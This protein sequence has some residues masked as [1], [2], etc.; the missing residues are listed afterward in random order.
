MEFSKVT[1]LTKLAIVV[2][3]LN[4]HFSTARCIPGTECD[5]ILQR[6]NYFNQLEVSDTLVINNVSL[7]LLAAEG[8]TDRLAQFNNSLVC[9]WTYEADTNTSRLPQTLY[10][11]RCST[12]TWCD[13]KTGHTYECRP[14]DEYRVPVAISRECDIF[15]Q[16]EWTLSFERVA[17]ACYPSHI[18]RQTA[19]ICQTLGDSS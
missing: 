9:P 8:S 15:G 12:E 14:Q 11:A 3:C 19:E 4:Y 2:V 7:N 17:V 16:T 1:V 6:V 13:H 10:R 5:Q 18:P